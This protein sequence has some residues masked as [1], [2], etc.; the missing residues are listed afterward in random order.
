MPTLDGNIKRE[1][2]V[3]FNPGGNYIAIRHRQCQLKDRIIIIAFII[4][5]AGSYYQLFTHFN[6]DSNY[7]KCLKDIA[8]GRLMGTVESDSCYY[9]L[10]INI[11]L[12]PTNITDEWGEPCH[13]F[14]C[15]IGGYFN[16]IIT[17]FALLPLVVA[18]ITS[19]GIIIL[20]HWIV[21]GVF[22]L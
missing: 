4:L 6:Q 21:K 20:I 13:S 9:Q 17:V 10:P 12:P 2:I 1:N 5:W 22:V 7:G 11:L 16:I 14:I 15:N 18:E 8:F 3:I 19:T